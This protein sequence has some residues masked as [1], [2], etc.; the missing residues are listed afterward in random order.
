MS[1]E[2]VYET[3]ATT[4]DNEAAIA[5]GWLPGELSPSGRE[6]ARALGARRRDDGIEVVYASDLARAAETA[7]IAFD[8]V[9]VDIPLDIHT[10]VRL[11]ECDYGD[12]NGSPTASLHPRARYVQTPFPG[13]QSY[14]DVI[15]QTLGFLA[16]VRR[17]HQGR[18]VL[19]IAHAANRWA[20][21]H[22]ATGVPLAA[23]VDAPFA[24][25]PGW[26]YVVT[27]DGVVASPT[28]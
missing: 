20:L 19:V 18:R 15:L 3:H 11:R 24:W 4:L 23:I 26:E 12:L 7:R 22:L 10:D 5:T 27:E 2:L 28:R 13:G 8:G 16:D 17:K 9:Q 25:Q 1:V 21:Q 6:Q 14:A